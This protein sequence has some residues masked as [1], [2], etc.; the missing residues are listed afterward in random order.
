MAQKKKQKKKSHK[1]LWIILAIAAV[2][3]VALI[4]WGVHGLK[5]MTKAMTEAMSS[6]VQTVEK[7]SIEV[8]TEG[9]GVVETADVHSENVDYNVT[10][11]RLYKENG[12]AVKAGEVIAEFQGAALDESVMALEEQLESLDSQLRYTS[13]EEN[14]TVTAP[15]SGRVKRIFAAEGDTVLAVQK[16]HQALAEISGDGRLKV[17]FTAEGVAEGQP[18]TIGYGEERLEGQIIEVKG[19]TATAT[20]SDGENYVLDT[21]TTIFNSEEV[22]IGAGKVASSHPVYVTAESGT[23]ESIFVKENEKV[24]AGSRIFK[25][26]DTGYASSYLAL[27]EQRE[28][29]ARKVEAAKA[30]R[31]GYVLTA[32]NDGIISELAFKE[33]D[34]IPA[35]TMFCKLLDTNAYQV[36]LSIDELDIQGIEQ[37]QKVEVTVDAI[38]DTIYEGEV[39]KVSMAGEN[40]NG[41]ASYQVSVLLKNAEGLL[42]GMS[43]NG[44][45]T[46]DTNEN[47]LLVPVDALQTADGEKSVTVVKNDG[48]TE[49]RKV[50]VGLVN[51]ENAEILEGVSEGEQVQVIVKLSDIY[52]QMGISLEGTE[53]E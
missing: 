10:L 36:S 21:E 44:K 12:E 47:A 45:I 8:I 33:G 2:L 24:S 6:N 28:Q 4:A 18:V 42:P 14:R 48:S 1:K 25:L 5:N 23:I 13:K 34:I 22:Q 52:S 27:L 38:E 51:N 39:S 7:G 15:V 37:G 26:A 11:S 43:A 50:T 20:F 53:L 32:K 49:T 17:E 30:Y 41:V 3:V 16:E 40:E 46:V 19:N 9:T 31:K 29:L 35:G